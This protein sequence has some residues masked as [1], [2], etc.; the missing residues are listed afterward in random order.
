LR[1]LAQVALLLPGASIRAG[2]PHVEAQVA[3]EALGDEHG[4]M[5]DRE[6]PAG[7]TF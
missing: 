7:Y 1:A 5:Q 6:D 2:R 4:E 3:W